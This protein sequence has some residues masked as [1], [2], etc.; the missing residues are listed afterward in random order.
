MVSCELAP[1]GLEY[2]MLIHSTQTEYVFNTE[3]SFP[4]GPFLAFFLS[5]PFLT[6][7]FPRVNPSATTLKL[8]LFDHVLMMPSVLGG[9]NLNP[10]SISLSAFYTFYYLAI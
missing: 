2:S 9:P 10:T 4:P 3:V 8:R 6:F 5:L 1:S 7:S